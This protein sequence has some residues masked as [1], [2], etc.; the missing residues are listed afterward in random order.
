[1]GKNLT[2]VS[3]RQSGNARARYPRIEKTKLRVIRRA[4]TTGSSIFSEEA[5]E[6]IGRSLGFTVR[7]GQIV[8]AVFD[9]HKEFA[10]AAELGI[11]THTVH[12]YVD[13]LHQKLGVPDRVALVLRVV[14]EFLKLTTTPGS[15]MPPI[16]ATRASGRC[17]RQAPSAS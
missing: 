5:W 8:R 12:T 17:H 2:P 4:G 1:M 15:L 11:S 14:N 13:R 3:P 10:I 6:K 9:D 7:E 16:C